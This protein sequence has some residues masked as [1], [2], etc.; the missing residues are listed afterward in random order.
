[1]Q[2][3]KALSPA[4]NEWI[5][6]QLQAWLDA[7]P[8]RRR[9]HLAAKLKVSPAHMTNVLT[10]GRGAGAALEQDVATLFGIGVDE[11]RR[12][13]NAEWKGNEVAV[14]PEDRYR[15]RAAAVEFMRPW[16]SG[17][18]IRQ[19]QSISLQSDTDPDPKWWADQ[20]EAADRLVRMDL[21]NPDRIAERD[22][23]A[24]SDADALESVTSPKRRRTK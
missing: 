18:A 13:A 2:H 21:R 4:V 3:G 24:A 17:E 10:R 19:V 6:A 15:N 22:Q 20:I 14:V 16:V 8:T 12:R 5:R 11:L 23:R 1:M 9:A 7:D